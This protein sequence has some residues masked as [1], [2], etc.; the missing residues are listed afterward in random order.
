VCVLLQFCQPQ[1]WEIVTKPQSPYFIPFVLTSETGTRLYCV[2]LNFYQ[3]RNNAPEFD[4]PANQDVTTISRPPMP[5]H[6]SLVVTESVLSNASMV[7]DDLEM[8]W[9]VDMIDGGTSSP[10]MEF[11]PIS[12]CAISTQPLFS[13]LKVMI[14][15]VSISYYT[16]IFNHKN[17]FTIH[18]SSN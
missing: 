12:L 13:I 1:G 18:P 11:E 7:G 16:S 8:Q 9:D 10:K 15:Y 17:K 5:Y 14:I 4:S 6:R 2:S 3:P